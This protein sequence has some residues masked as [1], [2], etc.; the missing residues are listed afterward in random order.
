MKQMKQ[1]KERKKERKERELYGR[2]KRP[3]LK[4]TY[5]P[6]KEKQFG[7]LGYNQTRQILPQEPPAVIS[8]VFEAALAASASGFD[9]SW[10]LDRRGFFGS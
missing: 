5:V 7:K 9:V 3:N 8:V 4:N 6:A 1:A 2:S 10:A